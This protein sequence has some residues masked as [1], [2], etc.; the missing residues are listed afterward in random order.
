MNFLVFH[1]VLLATVFFSVWL[2]VEREIQLLTVIVL[3]EFVKFWIG[4]S[5]DSW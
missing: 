3:Q 1:L 4:L 5:S 2:I